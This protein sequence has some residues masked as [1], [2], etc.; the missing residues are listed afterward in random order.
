MALICLWYSANEA[1][2]LNPVYGGA[3]ELQSSSAVSTSTS[4]SNFGGKQ[5]YNNTF[6]IA[7]VQELMRE[8]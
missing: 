8:S 5:T 6:A 3:V 1:G 2:E 4:T 7:C